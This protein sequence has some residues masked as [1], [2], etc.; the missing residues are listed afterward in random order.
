M[1]Q[2]RL[3]SRRPQ[4][5]HADTDRLKAPVRPRRLMKPG[6]DNTHSSSTGELFSKHVLVCLSAGPENATASMHACRPVSDD[7]GLFLMAADEINC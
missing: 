2:A 6:A 3:V 1:V 5:I 7:G 4:G